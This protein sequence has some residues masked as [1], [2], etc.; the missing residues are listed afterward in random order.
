MNFNVV[1]FLIGNLLMILGGCL[2][3]P[4][5]VA[6][7]FHTQGSTNLNEVF[8]FGASA[9]IS[10]ILGSVLRYMFKHKDIELKHREGFAVVSLSWVAITLIG[11]LPYLF[12]GATGT[13]TK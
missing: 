6:Y 5:M 10:I 2:I 4:L 8:A 9:A 7:Y 1:L 3:A 11:M 12:T 13:I